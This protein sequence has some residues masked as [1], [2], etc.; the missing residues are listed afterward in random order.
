M[1]MRENLKYSKHK[2]IKGKKKYDKYDNYDAIEVSF[3]DAIPSD[4]D[5]VMGVPISFL[6]KYNPDQFEILGTSD[7]G[8]VD[9]KFKKTP[10]LTKKFVAD[11]YKGGGT[12]AYKEGNPTAGIYENNVAKMVYKRIFIRNKRK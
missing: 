8:L 6:D 3:T 11:Y 4:Y 12:G 9:D 10:G 7:N 2:E 1:A 5:G